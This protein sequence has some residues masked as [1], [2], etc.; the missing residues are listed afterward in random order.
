MIDIHFAKKEKK[1][2]FKSPT[3][4]DLKRSSTVTFANFLTFVNLHMLKKLNY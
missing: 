2:E 1:K 4:G 3:V